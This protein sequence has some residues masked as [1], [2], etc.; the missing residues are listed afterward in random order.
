[1]GLR[2]KFAALFLLLLLVPILAV[3][4]LEID[5]TMAVMVDD[6]ADSG[7]LLINQTFEQMRSI[8]NKSKGNPA[9]ALA[10]SRTLRAF[11]RSS[12]AFGKGVVY[13]RIENPQGGAIV[14][15]AGDV[16]SALEPADPFD[17][18]RVRAAAWWP[19]TR[20]AS[21]WG[22]HTYEMSREVQLDHKPFAI[23]KIGLSTALIAAEVRRSVE[24]IGAITAG[25]IVIAILGAL[26]LGALMLRPLGEIAAGIERMAGGADE[27]RFSVGGH[28]EL[29]T[30]AEKFN[31][32]STRIRQNR[33]QWENERGQFF[34]I[35]RSITDA[36]I[37][38]DASGVI[39]FCNNEAQ[40]RLGLPAGG[41]SEGKPI[42]GLLGHDHPLIRMIDTAY[43]T[44]TEV[45]DVGLE[46]GNGASGVKLLVSVFSLGQGPEPPG[47]LVIARDLEP[48]QELENVVDYSGRLARLGGLISGVAHQIR[49][50]LNAM[51]LELELLRQD[52]EN[53][54]PLD[55]RIEAVRIEIVRLDQAVEA[56]MR[57]MRPERLELGDLELNGLLEEAADQVPIRGRVRIDLRLDPHLPMLRA[58]RA[59]LGEALKN[60]INNAIE[61][62]PNGGIVT[63]ATGRTG[64]AM[65]EI[66]V[67]D[68]GIGIAPEHLERIF[69]LY[70]T[71]KDSGTGLGLSLA[72]RAVD[73]HGGT[74]AIQSNVGVGTSVKIRLPLDSAVLSGVA[75]VAAIGQR[76]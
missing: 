48:V 33:S 18:L 55:G 16:G 12:R 36:V 27:V 2:V 67:T 71:T 26:L 65:V 66:A 58:D 37:L 59:L 34:N 6:L 74:I 49:N 50:P 44:G 17:L 64:D 4:A 46:L 15:S 21:L 22:E 10:Q 20:I 19:L 11:L 1:M 28:D 53:E 62:M 54:K 14:A 45:H 23:I 7:T 56:L 39:L 69:Q 43:A 40:G 31:Q 60:I 3:S 13:A 70:F 8:L 41:L 51:S 24:G 75:P 76:G 72:L 35:F 29:G 5:R 42:G 47:V 52:A 61:A 32:L 30:L 73:L 25:A 57:F 63:I 38:L 68:Q 9:A